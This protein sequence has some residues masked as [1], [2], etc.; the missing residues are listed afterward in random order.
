MLRYRVFECCPHEFKFDNFRCNSVAER[1]FHYLQWN[2]NKYLFFCYRTITF[3]YTS[4]WFIYYNINE[5]FYYEKL[6]DW[7]VFALTLHFA[8]AFFNSIYSTFFHT[9]AGSTTLIIEKIPWY[10]KT[11]W[12]LFNIAAT[13]S[14]FSGFMFWSD[15]AHH[16]SSD[17]NKSSLLQKHIV[18]IVFTVAETFMV[19]FPVRVLHFIY[20]LLFSSAYLIWIWSINVSREKLEISPFLNY[21]Y[22]SGLSKLID[23][24]TLLFVIPCHHI[25]YLIYKLKI[26]LKERK[27]GRSLVVDDQNHQ[28]SNK[29]PKIAITKPDN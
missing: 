14:L 23:V 29:I 1:Q 7:V 15:S 11:N 3:V 5:K 27:Q 28:I 22:F 25:F 21:E 9:L 13:T 10:C 8:V 12:I 24:V 18:N 20:P 19:D 2:E 16:L 6:V 17:N 4:S 26:C